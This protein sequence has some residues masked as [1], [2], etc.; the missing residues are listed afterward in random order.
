M[1]NTQT[2][3]IRTPAITVNMP[4]GG[5][6]KGAQQGGCALAS[7]RRGAISDQALLNSIRLNW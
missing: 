3:S 5:V 7:L 4:V 6:E 2:L 1:L